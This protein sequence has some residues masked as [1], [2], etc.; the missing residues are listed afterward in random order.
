[1]AQTWLMPRPIWPAPT[2]PIV[3]MSSSLMT[4][5]PRHSSLAK[6]VIRGTRSSRLSHDRPLTIDHLPLHNNRQCFSSS[7]TKTGQPS[8]GAADLHGIEQ[9]RKNPRAG[10]ADRMAQCDRPTVDVDSLWVEPQFPV[11]REGDG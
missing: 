10:G 2:I 9:R 3:L 6:I 1:M 5:S 7:D 8:L 11:D 4:S